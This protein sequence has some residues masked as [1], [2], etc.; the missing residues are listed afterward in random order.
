MLAELGKPVIVI[1]ALPMSTEDAHTKSNALETLNKLTDYVNAKRVQNLLVVDNAKI[2]AIYQDVSQMD[3]FNVANKAIVGPLDAFN[4]LSSMPSSTK[5]L[6]PAEFAKLLIDG[7]GLSVYGEL[8]VS[9]YEGETAIAEAVLNNLGTNLLA[10]EF[11]LKQSKYAG[12]IIAANKKVWDK[13]PAAHINYASSVVDEMCGNPKSIFKGFYV[14]EE[15]DD[16]L[17]I[18]SFFSGL[19][20]P[21]GRVE[22]LKKE[23]DE[24]KA[25]SRVKEEQR[26]STL[27]LNL[28]KNDTIS[29]AQKVKD[30][31]AVKN[32]AFGKLM[33]GIS[34]RRK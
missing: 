29:A 8:V 21:A 24:L 13:I 15:Q 1:A 31:I 18:Y 34:D 10:S 4:T 11:D 6:D 33:G 30:K 16:V 28:N 2:E 3:F 19:G 27:Q 22:Q 7:E 17:R 20:A 25:K 12:F 23:T 14:T 26:A 9:D 32:S 5:P